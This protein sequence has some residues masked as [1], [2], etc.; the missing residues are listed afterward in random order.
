MGGN[1]RESIHSET[2]R[3]ALHTQCLNA[4]ADCALDPV[5]QI[6][7]MVSRRADLMGR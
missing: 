1:G 5:S 7:H 6:G 4:I 3:L 2:R